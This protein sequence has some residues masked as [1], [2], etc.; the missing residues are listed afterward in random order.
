M[1]E[2]PYEAPQTKLVQITT[3][4]PFSAS[5]STKSTIGDWCWVYIQLT[6][7][8]A[9]Q[10][11]LQGPNLLFVFAYVGLL[12]VLLVAAFYS[13]CWFIY[14]RKMG[15]AIF[16]LL[17]ALATGLWIWNFDLGLM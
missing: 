1:S 2:N 15:L 17:F 6:V 4:W 5:P 8:I 14:Q 10:F 7:T 12:W 13:F 11:L 16:E 3:K 9:A